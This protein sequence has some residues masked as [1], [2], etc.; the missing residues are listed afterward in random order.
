MKQDVRNTNIYLGKFARLLR[1]VLENS[2][3]EKISLEK[4]VEMLQ[5]YLDLEK[6]RFGEDFNPLL[7]VGQA[8]E[9]DISYLPPMIIQPYIENAIKHGLFHQKGE[10]NLSVQFIKKGKEI[11]CEI[12]DNGIGRQA[13]AVI[14]KRRSKIHNSFSQ[15]A[16]EKRIDLINAVEEEKISLKIEDLNPG[17]LVSIGFPQKHWS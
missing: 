16:N 6:L 15:K 13:S 4:E 8:I 2:S 3:K 5:T 10:K 12:R 7:E 17:T 11:I 14:N 9:Q 1:L